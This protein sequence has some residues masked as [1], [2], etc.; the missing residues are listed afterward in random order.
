MRKFL[1]LFVAIDVILIFSIAYR[2]SIDSPINKELTTFVLTTILIVICLFLPSNKKNSDKTLGIKKAKYEFDKLLPSERVICEKYIDDLVY[3]VTNNTKYLPLDVLKLEYSQKTINAFIWY[4]AEDKIFNNFKDDKKFMILALALEKLEKAN[5]LEIKNF[6]FRIFHD[7]RFKTMPKLMN[8]L[9]SF[10][11]SQNTTILVFIEKYMEAKTGKKV[12]YMNNKVDINNNNDNN[13]GVDSV[14]DIKITK[15]N[16]IDTLDRP[17]KTK[18]YWIA[19][20]KVGYFLQ[21]RFDRY[22]G[23]KWIRVEPMSPKFDDM[24]FAYKNK[25]F[26]V[27]IDIKD[28]NYE[29]LTQRER[30]RFLKEC[31]ANNLIPCVFP[32]NIN[33]DLSLID[34]EK[35]NLYDIRTNELVNPLTIA[36]DEKIIMSTY[37]LNNMAIEIVKNYVRDRKMHIESYN[38]IIGVIP[39]VWFKDENNETSWIYVVYSTSNSFNNDYSDS[40]DKL[41]KGMPQFNGYLAEVGLVCAEGKMPYRGAGFYIKFDGIKKIYSAHR[42]TDHGYGIKIN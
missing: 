20:D 1:G 33:D 31:N 24:S 6:N 29:S 42:N 41:V 26:S 2:I 9:N 27:L 30:D 3:V 8:M 5:I 25:I 21:D 12:R 16:R 11:L 23:F 7:E 18:D 22:N 13:V 15:D 14:N 40:L 34:V 39:Q 38:D 32:I 17:S 35:W 37:E 36:T 10:P 19:R 4:Y 28:S